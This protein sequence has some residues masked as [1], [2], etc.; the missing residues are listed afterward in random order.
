[1]YNTSYR[2]VWVARRQDSRATIASYR[3]ASNGVSAVDEIAL[4]RSLRETAVS[5]PTAFCLSGRLGQGRGSLP[6]AATRPEAAGDSGKGAGRRS[7]PKPFPKQW[8]HMA[9]LAAL[10]GSGKS[11]KE[12]AAPKNFPTPVPASGR[13]AAVRSAARLPLF[14]TRQPI[15]YIAYQRCHTRCHAS[16]SSLYPTF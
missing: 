3:P 10:R 14:L 4:L 16:A 1:M 5:S 2:F 11:A 7:A 13:K 15:R 12:V 6:N 8:P 9:A